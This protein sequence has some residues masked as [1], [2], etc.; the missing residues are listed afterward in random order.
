M[1]Y[2]VIWGESTVFVNAGNPY[3]ACMFTMVECVPDEEFDIPLIFTVN[4]LSEYLIPEE[5]IDTHTV[6]S[7]LWLANGTGVEEV[8]CDNQGNDNEGQGCPPTSME[9][10]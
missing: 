10:N 3:Q 9:E 7:L 4:T 5:Q 2:E 6:I 8:Y 1:N